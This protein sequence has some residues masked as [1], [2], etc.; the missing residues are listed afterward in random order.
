MP[1]DCNYEVA[2]TLFVEGKAA[3]LIN[4]PWSWKSYEEAGIDFGLA[5]IPYNETAGHWPSPMIS[6]VGYSLNANLEGD[7]LERVKEFVDFL[8][9]TEVQLRY[10]EHL[11][12]IPNRKA[13][14]EDE[15]VQNHPRVADSWEQYR[16]GWQG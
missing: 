16:H 14:L 10:V 1:D 7:H 13:A 15:R 6:S 4:G 2:H 9:S 11:W 8:T 12:T 3:M 5:A